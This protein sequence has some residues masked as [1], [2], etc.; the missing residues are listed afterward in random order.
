MRNMF[1]CAFVFIFLANDC[2][3]QYNENSSN[4]VTI[5]M[6]DAENKVTFK[7]TLKME[8]ADRFDTPR[9]VEEN[10]D[11]ARITVTG[12]GYNDNEINKLHFDSNELGSYY[13]NG[14]ICEEK[15]VT[16]IPF[17]GVE[18]NSP[19]DEL[20]VIIRRVVDGSPSHESALL[21]GEIIYGVD[22]LD[23]W[24]FCDLQ[25]IISHSNI[26]DELTLLMGNGRDTYERTIIV[27]A[28]VQTEITFEACIPTENSID[29]EIDQ[30]VATV[31][32]KVFPN[33]TVG[34]TNLNFTSTSDE[35][36]KF[37]VLD[38]NGNTV[39]STSYPNFSGNIVIDYTFEKEIDGTYLFVLEQEGQLYQEKVS[40]AGSLETF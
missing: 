36:V 33:P 17:I 16:L 13:G 15:A 9:Y 12:F 18:A 5:Q 38:V 39:Y 30:V 24:T 3:S 31:D 35:E 8:E 4:T 34:R 37:Y 2:F 19:D 40:Y 21:E 14:P 29:V 10:W 25:Y 1:M 7:E 28:R 23:I 11:A 32:M 22:G 27:G 6:Y 20:G 26:G